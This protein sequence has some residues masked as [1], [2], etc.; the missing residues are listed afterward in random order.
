MSGTAYCSYSCIQSASKHIGVPFPHFRSIKLEI[1]FC[2]MLL[3]QNNLKIFYLFSNSQ[4]LASFIMKRNNYW[5]L[6]SLMRFVDH[7]KLSRMHQRCPSSRTYYLESSLSYCSFSKIFKSPSLAFA[8]SLGPCSA[9]VLL[10][11]SR[12]HRSFQTFV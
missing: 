11:G 12:W 9:H 2:S 3:A 8:S 4:F 10:F 1:Y 5:T 7:A 6:K